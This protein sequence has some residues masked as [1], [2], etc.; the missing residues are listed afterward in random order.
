MKF[1]VVGGLFHTVIQTWLECGVVALDT[2]L[3]SGF[4]AFLREAPQQVSYTSIRLPQ[5]A[6]NIHISQQHFAR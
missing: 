5:V 6:Y 2:N 3:R 4:A 1:E